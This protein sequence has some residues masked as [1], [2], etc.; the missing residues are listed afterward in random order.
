VG[1]RLVAF[2]RQHAQ[3]AVRHAP[4][5]PSVTVAEAPPPKPG[6]ALPQRKG[7]EDSAVAEPLK[8]E[9]GTAGCWDAGGVRP[10]SPIQLKA[11]C[12]VSA[13]TGSIRGEGGENGGAV[14]T[15]HPSLAPQGVS[16]LGEALAAICSITSFRSMPGAPAY[17][18]WEA[19]LQE[20]SGYMQRYPAEG[21]HDSS[22]LA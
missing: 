16:N 6:V 11:L 10:P 12:D 3:E 19:H 20:L 21:R 9:G 18:L 13:C 5:F 14:V 1:A 7:G 4:A 17:K 2:A 15:Y 22:P 8:G